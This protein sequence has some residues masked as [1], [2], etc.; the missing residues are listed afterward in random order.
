MSSSLYSKKKKPVVFSLYLPND[1]RM[2]VCCKCGK[3]TRE[4]VT[5]QGSVLKHPTGQCRHVSGKGKRM[6]GIHMVISAAV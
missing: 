6:E 3:F 4:V 1:C 2:Y 5:S